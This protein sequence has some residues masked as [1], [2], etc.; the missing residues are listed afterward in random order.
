MTTQT[1]ATP[2]VAYLPAEGDV[3]ILI[4]FRPTDPLGVTE[5][6]VDGGAHLSHAA[7]LDLLTQAGARLRAHVMDYRAALLYDRQ[8]LVG[9]QLDGWACCAA[10][11]LAT[12]TMGT[13]GV[14][15]PQGSGES[16]TD[17]R[18]IYATPIVCDLCNQA[19]P[20]TPRVIEG[21]RR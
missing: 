2:S 16:I 4:A 15:Y 7:Y 12:Y 11:F 10:C 9:Y 20:W 14:A 21:G 8:K 6:E 19:R 3:T 13:D 17:V 5:I 1:A 18:P